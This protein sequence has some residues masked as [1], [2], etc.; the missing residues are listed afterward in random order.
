MGDTRSNELRPFLLYKKGV[1]FKIIKCL[2]KSF[3][4]YR[5]V[6]DFLIYYK[7]KYGFRHKT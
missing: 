4:H 6:S 5:N 7:Q 3:L 1:P 2:A